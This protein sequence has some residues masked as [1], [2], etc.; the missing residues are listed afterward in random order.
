MTHFLKAHMPPKPKQDKSEFKP[1]QKYVAPPLNDSLLRFYVSTY[2]Q[3]K[4]KSP[5]AEKWL[6]EHGIFKA[7]KAARLDAQNRLEK[8]MTK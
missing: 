3:K 8:M 1:G 4:F 6:L 7:A 5:M 2:R